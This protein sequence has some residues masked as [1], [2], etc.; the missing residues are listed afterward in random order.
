MQDIAPTISRRMRD[1]AQREGVTPAEIV[2]EFEEQL[3]Y[4]INSRREKLTRSIFAIAPLHQ[5]SQISETRAAI[6]ELK[7][8]EEALFGVIP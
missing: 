6:R 4:H 2:K 5:A 7:E 1:V 3:A 8:L